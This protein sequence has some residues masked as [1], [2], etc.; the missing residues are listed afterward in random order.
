[1]RSGHDYVLIGRRAALKA[2]IRADRRGLRGGAAARACGAQ[3][4]HGIPM[5]DNKNTILAIA[6]SAIVLIGW[7]FFFAMPQEKAQ[8]GE[9]GSRAADAKA[10]AGAAAGKPA[11]RRST[12]AQARRRRS[13]PRK[14]AT[15]AAAHH[16]RRGAGNVAAR[17]DRDRQPARLDRAQRRTHRRS[18]AAQVPR[19][20]RPEVAADR[21]AVAV[22]Q[23]G[24]VLRRVRLDQ[25]SRRQRQGAGVGHRMEPTGLGRARRRPSGDADLGQWRGP[26]I[27]PHHR[28][29]R[30]ISVHRS[31]TRW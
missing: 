13:R 21:S 31:R 8:T 18:G 23:P 22:R 11:S 30:Q 27:P 7:Q 9:T 2:A 24:S 5:T 1:M 28:G 19:N 14:P 10:A 15:S 29:R 26:R 17:F 25:R 6:L 3:R 12:G 16:P 4:Q 20:G